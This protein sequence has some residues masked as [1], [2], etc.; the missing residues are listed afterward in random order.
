MPR[1]L[2]VCW[3]APNYPG[4]H[5][6]STRRCRLSLVFLPRRRSVGD[7]IDGYA[8]R[9]SLSEIRQQRE[10]RPRMSR[11]SLAL[12][13]D[14]GPCWRRAFVDSDLGLVSATGRPAF[15]Q[16]KLMPLPVERTRRNRLGDAGSRCPS[17]PTDVV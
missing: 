12:Q 13:C 3:S 6:D 14:G 16:P 11:R 8:R 4:W 10:L 2:A 7:R 15:F 17:H 1:G 5:R 9:R